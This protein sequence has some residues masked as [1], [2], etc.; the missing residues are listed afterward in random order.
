[1]SRYFQGKYT[2]KNPQKYV[3]DPSNIVFRSSWER[4]FLEWAD[5]NSKVLNYSS[6]ELHIPYFFVPDGRWHRY[7]PDFILTVR[8]KD[9]KTSVW[10]VEIKPFAQTQH[11]RTKAYKNQKRL[12]KE[13]LEYEKNQ[14][15]WAAANIF[16]NGKGWKFMVLT[17]KNLFP[18]A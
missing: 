7:F 18:N 3:G 15:K 17:E 6:E 11:P 12:L 10:M 9:D 1:M 14:S 4:H 8:G 5:T 2:P 16:C 13:S